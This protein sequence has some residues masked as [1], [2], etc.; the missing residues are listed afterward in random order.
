LQSPEPF[1]CME[2]SAEHQ[3]KRFTKNSVEM[4]RF[5]YDPIGRRVEKVGRGGMPGRRPSLRLDGAAPPC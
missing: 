2:W 3:L 5:K 1:H 4:A